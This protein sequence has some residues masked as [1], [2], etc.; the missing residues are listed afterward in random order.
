MSLDA[1]DCLAA[2]QEDL[3]RALDGNDLAGITRAVAALGEAIEAAHALGQAPLQPQ[4]GERLARLSAL[5]LAA[6]M[7]VNYLTDRVNGRL[8][9][10]ASLTG[11]S[12]PITY[13]AGL[14]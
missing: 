14:R 5:A 2:A 11:Q 1:L 13:H 8:A 9:G 6:R 3:I 12:G 10:L 4:L 7:R